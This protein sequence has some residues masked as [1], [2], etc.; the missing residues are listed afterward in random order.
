M[1]RG[2]DKASGGAARADIVL[3]AVPATILRVMRLVGLDQV[4]AGTGNQHRPAG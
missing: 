2:P 4:F 1:S 3:A